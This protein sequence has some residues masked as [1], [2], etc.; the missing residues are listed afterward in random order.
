MG[1]TLYA[2]NLTPDQCLTGHPLQSGSVDISIR[3]DAELEHTT[4]LIIYS[5]YE[6]NVYIDQHRNCVSDIHG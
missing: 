3:F 1:N 4:S 6:N 5:Q 2:F